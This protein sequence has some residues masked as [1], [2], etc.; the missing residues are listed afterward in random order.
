MLACFIACSE[1]FLLD[2]FFF[3]RSLDDDD[4]ES[5]FSVDWLGELF[6]SQEDE[7][8]FAMSLGLF[9]SGFDNKSGAEVDSVTSGELKLSDACKRGKEQKAKWVATRLAT[10][11]PSP[12]IV[13]SVDGEGYT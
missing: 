1:I 3:I 8:F 12:L 2:L 9:V 10:P 7:E 4:F 5:V 6:K 11:P 13:C